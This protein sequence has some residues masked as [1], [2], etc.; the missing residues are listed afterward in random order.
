[1]IYHDFDHI[2]DKLNTYYSS[3][4]NVETSNMKKAEIGSQIGRI[5]VKDPTV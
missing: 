1:M 3:G 5:L 4:Q 2:T